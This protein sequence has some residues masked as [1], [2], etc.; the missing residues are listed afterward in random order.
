MLNAA[1]RQTGWSGNEMTASR[2][3]QEIAKQL[4]RVEWIR[5]ANDVRPFPHNAGRA[6][7]GARHASPATG[8]VWRAGVPRVGHARPLQVVDFVL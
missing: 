8:G 3:R 4:E 2:W 7:V 1:L 5:V 6:D